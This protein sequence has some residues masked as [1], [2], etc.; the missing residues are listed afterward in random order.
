M[1]EWALRQSILSRVYVCE[2][3]VLHPLLYFNVP[4]PGPSSSSSQQHFT[5]APRVPLLIGFCRPKHTQT[6]LL[7]MLITA[8][9]QRELDIN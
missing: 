8:C 1:I 2:F 5:A 6:D 7:Y 9:A 3:C 4:E